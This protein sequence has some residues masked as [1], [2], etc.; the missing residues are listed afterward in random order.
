MK[1]IILFLG[2]LALFYSCAIVPPGYKGV[3][4][5]LLGHRRGPEVKVLDVGIHWVG[6]YKR[7]YNFPVFQ[8]D[9]TW[10]HENGYTSV[11]PH[12]PFK[13]QSKEGINLSVD[14]GVS[15]HIIPDSVSAVFKKWRRDIRYI[16]NVYFDDIIHDALIHVAS[17]MSVE[18]IYG[19][20]KH[21]L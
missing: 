14:L 20:K 4:V 5:Y 12:D 17:G 19:P 13:F 1:K 16:A 11:T 21:G 10:G 7:I 9:F 3:K 6:L 18:E 15:F 8:Q 2:A